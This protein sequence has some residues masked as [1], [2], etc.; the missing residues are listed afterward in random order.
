MSQLA[1]RAAPVPSESSTSQRWLSDRRSLVVDASGNPLRKSSGCEAP[2]RE[3]RPCTYA[4]E[5]LKK[6]PDGDLAASTSRKVSPDDWET[7]FS[8]DYSLLLSVQQILMARNLT[9]KS[10]VHTDP[11][12]SVT[13]KTLRGLE[14]TRPFLTFHGP[15][16]CPKFQTLLWRSEFLAE[17]VPSSPLTTLLILILLRPV[18]PSAYPTCGVLASHGT[19]LCPNLLLMRS[20]AS[21]PGAAS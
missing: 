18:Q 2:R 13:S 1:Q 17:T 19:K 7:R 10:S 21:D 8:V 9:P 5:S 4:K 11:Q 6:C 14:F 12:A 15:E 3:R 16:M 20:R